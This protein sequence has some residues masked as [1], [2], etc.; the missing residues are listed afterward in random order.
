MALGGVRTRRF[1]CVHPVGDMPPVIGIDL[2][3]IDANGLDPV[4]MAKDG[5]N[6][7]PAFD[8]QQ[9]FAARTDEGQRLIGFARRNRAQDVEARNDRAVV[10]RR[11][12]D[13]REHRT[14][15]ERNDAPVAVDDPS[16][17]RFFNT[18]AFALP[19]AGTFGNAGRNTII[20]PGSKGLDA[21]LTKS[22][23][24]GPQRVLTARVQATN[25]LNLVQFAAIDTV[26]NSPTFGQ[27]I[28]MRPMRSIQ[29]DVRFRF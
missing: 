21:A 10:V 4:D 18:A 3:G 28:S 14:R 2:G 8:L 11:P 24:L 20:G 16:I 26:V 12:A 1:A 15:T 6:L 27:V 25:V 5:L 13:E 9:D 7:R 23:T 17:A 29:F 22:I 19:A